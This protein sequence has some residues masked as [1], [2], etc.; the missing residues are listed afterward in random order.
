MQFYPLLAQRSPH[1]SKN[2]SAAKVLFL[3]E[4]NSSA[5][6]VITAAGHALFTLQVIN[7]NVS[8]HSKMSPAA[9]VQN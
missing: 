3:F 9:V 5:C 4:E 7:E 2:F 6:K 1:D 8:R